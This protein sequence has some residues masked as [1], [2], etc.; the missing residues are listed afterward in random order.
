MK[1]L[2]EK[3]NI[4]T[5]FDLTKGYVYNSKIKSGEHEEILPGTEKMNDGKGLKTIITDYEDVQ[6]YHAYTDAELAAKNAPTLETRVS[7][8]ESS[9]LTI[10]TGGAS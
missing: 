1:T 10:V 5:A 6:I 2:D 4:I 7:A 3:G 8:L 9:L